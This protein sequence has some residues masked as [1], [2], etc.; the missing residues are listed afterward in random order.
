MYLSLARQRELLRVVAQMMHG[1]DS[2]E[3]RERTGHDLLRLLRADYYASY[4][5]NPAR[6][7]FADRVT[8]N[9]DPANLYNYDIHYQFNDPMTFK[10][11][12]RRNATR[13]SEIIPQRE[14]VKTEFFNDF[15]FRD[16]LYWGVN[17]YAHDGVLNIGDVRI[18]RGKRRA[19]FDDDDIAVLQLVKPFFTLAM[20]RLQT[21]SPASA[22]KAALSDVAGLRLTAREVEVARLLCAGKCDKDIAR[23]LGIAFSTVRTHLHSLFE[24]LGVSGRVALMLRLMCP[25]Y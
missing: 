16:G 9:M 13:V 11:Q 8:I 17:L 3:V 20:K 23:A 25:H 21:L 24:K 7:V 22:A 19:N 5:W 18:W 6:R 1:F 4:V 10:L 2:A 15:L 14:L 12:R